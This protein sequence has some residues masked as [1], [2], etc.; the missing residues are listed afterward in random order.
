[1]KNFLIILCFLNS[2]FCFGQEK[3]K[4]QK[5]ADSLLA[6]KQTDKLISFFE[7]ELKT[8][9]KNEN[10]LRWIGFVHL[11]DNNFDK[12]EKF[13]KQA[14]QANPKCAQCYINLA[15]I[16]GIQNLYDKAFENCK[17]A[18]EIE[19]SLSVAYAFRGKLKEA[20]GDMF[21]A[22]LDY[23]KAI[24]LEPSNADYYLLRAEYNAG[25]NYLLLAYSDIDKAIKL[26]PKNWK[27]YHRKSELFYNAGKLTDALKYIG[28]AIE[29]DS[30]QQI[31]YG[32]RGAIYSN[33][34]EYKL[35]F[36]DYE[37]AIKLNPDDYLP[38]YN[39]YYDKYNLE[40]MDGSCQDL[41]KC[42][43]LLKKSNPTHEL[44]KSLDLSIQDV[45]DSTK[46]SYYYQRG[47]AYF[48]L[49]N[50]NKAITCYT[51]CLIKFPENTLAL[52]FRGNAYFALEEYQNALVDFYSCISYKD[53]LINDV[54]ANPRY[55]TA[56]EDSIKMYIS[57]FLAAMQISIAESK[58]G[59]HQFNE[60]LIEI[61][62]G[63]EIAPTNLKDLGLENYY[64]VR[65]NI[66]MALANFKDALSDFETCIKLNPKFPFAYVNRAVANIYLPTK[67]GIN[68]LGL[69]IA[70]TGQAFSANWKL[71]NFSVNK[72]N[73]QN[74]LNALSDCNKTLELE[75]KCDFALYVRGYL[76]KA[77]G[78]SDYCL[79]F[80]AAKQLGY[81]VEISLL[82]ECN[83]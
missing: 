56:G 30:N 79:D 83:K 66:Y 13:Y 29:L 67:N 47:I 62:K 52:Q 23:D 63:I 54:K 69:N 60:A 42:Y 70:F 4:Y 45:C 32:G 33:L 80:K 2:V 55:A 18:I 59:L 46:P 17:I 10:I 78:Y 49:K 20:K 28:K 73:N 72:K 65:G 26:N 43:Q 15:R 38:Y 81:P 74:L 37:K 16:Y 14:I 21:S 11:T 61:N 53:K 77:L 19:P 57:G 58:F 82:D 44:L 51:Q 75:P 50:Y 71:G 7:K 41:V 31:L 36:A 27:A 34:K 6:L 25:Q 12:A 8:Y 39:R 40:D 35:A 24:E 68:S 9:P 76:K 3:D 48:N 64:N 22:L 1:M 5:F